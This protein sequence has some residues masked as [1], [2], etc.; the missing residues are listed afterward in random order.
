M[1]KQQQKKCLS[2]SYNVVRERTALVSYL[3]K[4][5]FMCKRS[6][7]NSHLMLDLF[8]LSYYTYFIFQLGVLIQATHK[9]AFGNLRPVNNS[10]LITSY[11]A[12]YDRCNALLMLHIKA[13]ND[14]NLNLNVIVTG[15]NQ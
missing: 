3:Q 5:Q 15:F 7:F 8:F 9:G 11:T 6:R 4:T 1:G 12:R 10:N 2:Q 14:T 13:L